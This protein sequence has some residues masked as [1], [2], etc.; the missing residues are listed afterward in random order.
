[1]PCNCK[2]IVLFK[3]LVLFLF[4]FISVKS[5]ST[6]KEIDSLYNEL[7]KNGLSPTEIAHIMSNFVEDICVTHPRLALEYV[8]KAKEIFEKENDILNVAHT[9]ALLGYIYSQLKLNKVA[10]E[11][12]SKTY[13]ALKDSESYGVLGWNFVNIGNIYYD[14][15]LYE[16]A[17]EYYDLALQ[18]F[19]KEEHHHGIGVVNL[20]YGLIKENR[21]DLDSA[22]FYYLKVKEIRTLLNDCFLD[23][24]ILTYIS[25]VYTAQGDYTSA[26]NTLNK[27]NSISFECDKNKYVL[28]NLL[29]SNYNNLSINY[30]NINEPQKAILFA[31]SSYYYASLLADT[32]LLVRALFLKSNIYINTKELNNAI[33]TYL[34]IIDM[35][36]KAGLYDLKL[37]AYMKI[38]QAYIMQGNNQMAGYYLEAYPLL[39]DTIEQMKNLERLIDLKVAIDTYSRDKEIELLKEK[40][41]DNKRIIYLLLIIGLLLVLFVLYYFYFRTKSARR[42]S[43]IIDALFD[44]YLIHEN[45]IIVQTNKALLKFTGYSNKELIKKNLLEL[46]PDDV[47]RQVEKDIIENKLA[48]YRT[49]VRVKTQ[50]F[51][52]VDIE[53][54]PISFLGRKMRIIAIKDI[55]QELK[56]IRQITLFK[57]IIEQNYDTV[58]ITDKE[59]NIEYVNPSFTQITGYSFDEV[60]GQNPKILKSNLH[61]PKFYEQ[62]WQT[63]SSG[64][65]WRGIFKNKTKAGDFF[66][67]ESTITPIKEQGQ[68]LKYVAIKKDITKRVALE[69]RLKRFV[70]ELSIVFDKIE[71]YVMVIDFNTEEI[72]F[73]NNAAQGLF[74]IQQKSK[75]KEVVFNKTDEFFVPLPQEPPMPYSKRYNESI[76]KEVYI[77][78][79]DSWFDFVFQ[80]IEWTDNKTSVLLMAHNISERKNR[81]D[82]L[83]ELN[84]TKDKFFSIISH[85]MKNPFQS[86]IGFSDML[87]NNI[88][89][90][91]TGKVKMILEHIRD[92]SNN[93]YKLLENLLEWSRS[94]TGSIKQVPEKINVFAI[95]SET[96]ELLNKIAD[97]KD[98]TILIEMPEDLYS[99]S[100]KHIL[101][102]V[103]RN[104]IT[105]AIKFTH[106]NGLVKITAE[107]NH[108]DITLNVIDNGIGIPKEVQQRLFEIG[109]NFTV[110]GTIGEKGTGLGLILC[111]E[112][113]ELNGG[114]IYVE[115]TLGAGSKFSF[116]VPKIS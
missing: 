50:D 53:A 44:G 112:L 2:N 75:Y 62:L 105:N 22:L 21:N 100:D 4:F 15:K 76:R 81:I 19:E 38:A 39:Q 12:Y 74:N 52:D 51:V 5:F 32:A 49:K 99:F 37:K 87:L 6:N 86:L 84:A 109:V 30:L 28:N 57:S 1:M 72:L 110:N 13:N 23:A 10:I 9:D 14:E 63:I 73:S 106:R 36:D 64:K 102:M 80:F 29:S 27:S 43:Q 16:F 41:L 65:A 116:T 58:V 90:N 82:K 46:L 7:L 97:E 68:I 26:I 94:Q 89:L 91:E 69:E 114:Q 54:R 56:H 98:I 104:L 33:S 78:H 8:H 66:W 55:R 3:G 42:I 17:K 108:S 34:Q 113:V 59:G 24:H 45:G 11:Y 95:T 115:S 93:A 40:N 77:S 107:E 60:I 67:E 79:L 88:D 47:I 71:A 70:E 111:K 103:L 20:N 31:D 96:C 25:R 48:N 83:N 61:S 101:S 92:V 85:D 18:N 35:S